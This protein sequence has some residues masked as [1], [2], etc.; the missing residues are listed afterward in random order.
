MVPQ[1]VFLAFSA[2]AGEEFGLTK[3]AKSRLFLAMWKTYY[4]MK[5]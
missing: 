2:K 5:Q 1:E 4:L 3:G